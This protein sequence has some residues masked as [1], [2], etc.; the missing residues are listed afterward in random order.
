MRWLTSGL[1]ILKLR[2]GSRQQDGL[3]V[4]FGNGRMVIFFGLRIV[5]IRIPTILA[6]DKYLG[7]RFWTV[8]SR[9][10]ESYSRTKLTDYLRNST[11]IKS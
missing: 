1:I 6:S 5:M 3:L 7:A 2:D 9:G 4:L 10:I 8:T 11:S